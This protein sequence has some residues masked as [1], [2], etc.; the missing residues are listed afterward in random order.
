ML[1]SSHKVCDAWTFDQTVS[2][3][4]DVGSAAD[5]LKLIVA[6]TFTAERGLV[7]R[8]VGFGQVP[9]AAENDPV[10]GE[11]ELRLAQHACFTPKGVSQ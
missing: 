4:S 8:P 5:V 2:Q 9:H 3:L 6:T 11:R 10:G 1:H 7:D